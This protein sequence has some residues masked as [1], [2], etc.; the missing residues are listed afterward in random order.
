M[1]LFLAVLAVLLLQN[2]DPVSTEAKKS[3][4]HIPNPEVPLPPSHS[5]VHTF[6]HAAVSSDSQACSDIARW[7]WLPRCQWRFRF[8]EWVTFGCSTEPVYNF[9]KFIPMSKTW[10]YYKQIIDEH[11]GAHAGGNFYDF[12]QAERYFS[13]IFRT[14]SIVEA[15]SCTYQFPIRLGTPNTPRRKNKIVYQRFKCCRC[16]EFVIDGL[17]RGW[18]LVAKNDTFLPCPLWSASSQAERIRSW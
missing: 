13:T 12:P 6:K 18:V 10:N 7:G 2:D 16:S 9:V 3:R 4:R 14:M 8:R 17:R 15:N 11:C 1:L 5:V